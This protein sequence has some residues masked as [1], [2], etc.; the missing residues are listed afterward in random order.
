MVCSSTV[1]PRPVEQERPTL[2]RSRV[3]KIA[4]DS[5]EMKTPGLTV[6]PGNE[7]AGFDRTV[8]RFRGGLALKAHRLVYH[9]TLGSR[10]IKKKKR[11]NR[12]LGC[13]VR[14]TRSSRPI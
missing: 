14:G 9:S 6:F 12:E 2:V 1:V 8:E 7:E 11:K 5:Q 3:T 4:P 13:T 10:V